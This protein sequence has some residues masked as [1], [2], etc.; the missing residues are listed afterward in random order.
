M[1]AIKP[2]K[3][4][5]KEV[6]QKQ[7]TPLPRE[8]F[9]PPE[10][11]SEQI[12]GDGAWMNFRFSRVLPPPGGHPT[13]TLVAGAAASRPPWQPPFVDHDALPAAAAHS[14]V[15]ERRKVAR[16]FTQGSAERNQF[17]RRGT[18]S[19]RWRKIPTRTM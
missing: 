11:L 8:H 16:E 3:I 12:S 7:A 10:I 19:R 17:C 18:K 15:Q 1:I 6:A 5:S 2:P 9:S 13:P 4:F 14:T